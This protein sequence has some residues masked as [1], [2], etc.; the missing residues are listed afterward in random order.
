MMD[1]K[2]HVTLNLSANL[3][4]KARAKAISEGSNLSAVVSDFL[5]A[6]LDGKIEQP[7][8]EQQKRRRGKV[9]K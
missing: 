8:P 3:T 4:Q 7:K 6:W 1:D 9:I 2:K 5:Q